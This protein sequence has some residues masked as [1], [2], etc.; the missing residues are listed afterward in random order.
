MSA[1]IK[2]PPFR[3]PMFDKQG[4]TMATPW[5]EWFRD[6]FVQVAN[7]KS[8]GGLVL[9][10]GDLVGT[11]DTQTLSNKTLVDPIFAG[12]VDDLPLELSSGILRTVFGHKQTIINHATDVTL[13]L[14]DLRKIHVFDCSAQDIVVDLPAVTA[15]DKGEGVL[16]VRTGTFG[17]FVNPDDADTILDSD[18]GARNGHL[19]CT[20]SDY[21]LQ[22]IALILMSETAWGNGPGSFGLWKAR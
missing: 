16:L 22:A 14:T 20:D 1:D 8:V 6:L 7:P 4:T 12:V 2:E 17:L 21:D 5:L 3:T 9:P 13:A 19:E 10:D 18:I 11:T 15:S